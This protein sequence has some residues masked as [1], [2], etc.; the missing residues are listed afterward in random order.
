[1]IVAGLPV[2]STHHPGTPIYYLGSVLLR[3]VGTQVPM[4]QTFLNV[5]YLVTGVLTMVALWMFVRTLGSLY[6]WSVLFV[7][8][9]TAMVWPSF[10]LHLNYFGSDSFLVAFGLIP[11]TLFWRSLHS[12][13]PSG[14][15]LAATGLATG[16]C[17]ATKLVFVP[18]A[19]ALLVGTSLQVV[20]SVGVRRSFPALL[21]FPAATVG[22][23]LLCVSPVIER[24]VA[25][26]YGVLWH[27]SNVTGGSPGTW[28]QS[29]PETLRR[30]LVADAPLIAV[31]AL[32]LIVLLVSLAWGA[33]RRAPRRPVRE[34]PRW[35][36]AAGPF[37]RV[38]GGTF[39]LLLGISFVL[40]LLTSV[41]V[42]QEHLGF[43]LRY[44]TPGALC[45]PFLLLFTGRVRE[46][47]APIRPALV[48]WRGRLATAGAL[49]VAGY[50][51][52]AHVFE[53]RRSIQSMAAASQEGA[54]DVIQRANTIPGGR[55]A[56]WDGSP[57]VSGEVSFHLWGNYRYAS[58]RFTPELLREFPGWTALRL[59]DACRSILVSEGRDTG[60]TRSRTKYGA[61][62]EWFWRTLMRHSPYSRRADDGALFAGELRSK[63]LVT[64][65]VMREVEWS[66]E[67]PNTPVQTLAELSEAR[68]GPAEIERRVIAG[69]PW[70]FLHPRCCDE[71]L[72]DGRR[73][74]VTGGARPAPGGVRAF[75]E[76]APVRAPLRSTAP[77]HSR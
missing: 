3:A 37:D 70:I 30:V 60:R 68:V 5:A 69:E 55:V 19:A 29:A 66:L 53:R 61:A 46:D 77:G 8:L 27:R 26:V 48:R 58:E 14:A 41:N 73:S 36:S 33:A 13:T 39:L 38:A 2:H 24:S 32:S 63:E 54:L 16:L 40:T 62:G 65:L 10:L 4:T 12:L 59:R 52:V 21:V 67:C 11:I 22:G 44:T 1:V 43:Q 18:L 23:F 35:L 15:L 71:P 6:H 57:G 64:L 28:L 47:V 42:K 9:A 74:P 17:L 49:L 50:A 25:I 56:L 7:A 72:L 20:R 75:D 51:V 45:I 31:T 76:A 34:W